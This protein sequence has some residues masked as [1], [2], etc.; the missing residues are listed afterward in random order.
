MMRLVLVFVTTASVVPGDG[1][2]RRDDDDQGGTPEK[3]PQR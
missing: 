2:E 3:P 1:V